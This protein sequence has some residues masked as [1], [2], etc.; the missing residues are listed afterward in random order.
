MRACVLLRTGLCRPL[1]LL[2][3]GKQGRTKNEILGLAL[4]EGPDGGRVTRLSGPFECDGHKWPTRY[5][6]GKPCRTLAFE[7]PRESCHGTC[8]KHFVT[9]LTAL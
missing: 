7:I 1:P 8:R 3:C 4:G 9:V 5:L 6:P 2:V